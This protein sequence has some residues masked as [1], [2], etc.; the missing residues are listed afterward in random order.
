MGNIPTSRQALRHRSNIR[1]FRPCWTP[2]CCTSSS[3]KKR[4]MWRL[5]TPVQRFPTTWSNLEPRNMGHGHDMAWLICYMK[6]TMSKDPKIRCSNVLN[7][8]KS[9]DN[10]GFQSEPQVDALPSSRPWTWMPTVKT[11]GTVIQGPVSSRVMVPSGKQFAIENG[12]WN[13]CFSHEKWW[14]S[15]VM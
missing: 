15:I 12:Y 8:S 10:F 13:R 4:C 7:G 5:N 6:S 14:F 3:T 11:P 2:N 9:V 1:K